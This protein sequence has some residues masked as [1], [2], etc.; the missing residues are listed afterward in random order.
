MLDLNKAQ[1]S[2]VKKIL[3]RFVPEAEVRAFGSRVL[4]TARPTSDLDLALLGPQP[5]PL[6]TMTRLREAFEESL[7]PF[8][9]DLIDWHDMSESFRALVQKKYEVM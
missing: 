5:I 2:E 9:V 3:E 6:S 1:L 8:R 7:L 4:G